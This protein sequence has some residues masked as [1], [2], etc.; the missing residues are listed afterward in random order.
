MENTRVRDLSKSEERRFDIQTEKHFR[1]QRETPKGRDYR[2]NTYRHDDF[3][4]DGKTA[5]QN[6]DNNFN[7][8]FPAS[9]GSPAWFDRKFGEESSK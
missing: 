8:T 5:A 2:W 1:S 9:P 4:C 3:K 7:D 6:F